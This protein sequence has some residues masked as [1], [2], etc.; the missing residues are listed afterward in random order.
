MLYNLTFNTFKIILK[1]RVCSE[2]LLRRDRS[3]FFFFSLSLELFLIIYFYLK[4]RVMDREEETERDLSH[5]GLG[6]GEMRRLELPPGLL[7]G[8]RHPGT[9][10]LFHCHPKCISFL[11][12]AATRN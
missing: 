2:G 8:C 9:W 12:S 5:P 6:L 11:G 10:A 4:D 1:H 7:Y 3:A